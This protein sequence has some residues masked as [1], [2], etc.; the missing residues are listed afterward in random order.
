MGFN[1]AGFTWVPPGF[2]G[3][4]PL[5]VMT[6]GIGWLLVGA[7][8][9]LVLMATLAAVIPASRAARLKVVDA[10]RHV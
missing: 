1:A 6:S 8:A 4:S 7:W 9:G 2:A 3:R 5:R 10:L